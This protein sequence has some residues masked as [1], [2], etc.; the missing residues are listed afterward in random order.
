M[1]VGHDDVQIGLVEGGV[2]VAA[3]PNNHIRFRFG[4]AQDGFVI[5]PRI[6]H[7]PHLDVQLIFLALFDGAIVLF[8][9]FIGGEALHSLFGQIAI[10][11]GVAHGHNTA[12]AHL[13]QQPHHLAR[14]L[15]LAA[16]RAHGADGHDGFV[17]LEHG[18]VGADKAEIGASGQHPRTEV[19][20]GLVRDIGVGHG[21]LVDAV[22][23]Y[24]PL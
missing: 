21:H 12:V 6:N 14:C 9:V 13:L 3:I 5:H 23:L 2:V 4:A 20:G 19:H 16:P 1:R 10:G 8:H 7:C 11:H 22:L 24:Q 15:A 17:A 18:V